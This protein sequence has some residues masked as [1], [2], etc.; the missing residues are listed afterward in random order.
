MRSPFCRVLTLVFLAKPVLCSWTVVVDE[1]LDDASIGTGWTDTAVT[2]YYGPSGRYGYVHG[3]CASCDETAGLYGFLSAAGISKT[4]NV[5]AAHTAV[6]VSMRIWMLD[7]WVNEN[8]YI[9]VD[10]ADQ[11]DSGDLSN[12][13]CAAGWTAWV[14]A[15]ANQ[16]ADRFACAV[17]LNGAATRY[18]CYTDVELMLAHDTTTLE[19]EIFKDGAGN[20]CDDESFGVSEV[21]IAYVAPSSVPTASPRTRL[22]P[23]GRVH[24]RA[25][26]PEVPSADV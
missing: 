10:G 2:D 5:P 14:G 4:F 15:A 11:W 23:A 1:G 17:G 26:D 16:P 3:N 22:E 20:D 9:K 7:T 24:P 25:P 13:A 12:V 19:L 18:T 6:R 8:V 21:Q